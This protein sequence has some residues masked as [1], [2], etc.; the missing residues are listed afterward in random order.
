MLRRYQIGHFVPP[1]C[2]LEHLGSHLEPLDGHLSPENSHI[3]PFDDHIGLLDGHF[4][5]LGGH[6]WHLNDYEGILVK[7]LRFNDSYL[8][9]SKVN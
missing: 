8:P 5:P 7:N 9:H 6:I 3:G 2:F 4:G 1:G